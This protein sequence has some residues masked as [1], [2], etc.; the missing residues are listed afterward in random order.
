MEQ[1]RHRFGGGAEF[2][3]L[4]LGGERSEGVAGRPFA[5]MER[6]A[7]LAALVG[8]RVK[9]HGDPQLPGARPP[10]PHSAGHV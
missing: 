2:A 5:A 3:V 9:A 1:E 4:G 7:D 6:A 10:V 8:D